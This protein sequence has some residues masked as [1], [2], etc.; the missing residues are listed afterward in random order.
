MVT[1][2]LYFDNRRP[3]KKGRG[4]LRFVI[5]KKSTTS[6][7]STGIKLTSDQW[8]G[9]KVV[10]HPNSKV[11]NSALKIN[12]GK[13][14]RLLIDLANEGR[15]AGKSASEIVAVLQEE[16]DPETAQRRKEAKDSRDRQVNSVFAY[17]QK[18][19]ALKAN[20]GTR[21]LYEDTYNKLK[22]YCEEN[23][24]D[25]LSLCFNDVNRT[26]L[27]SFEQFCLKTQKQNTASRHLRDI[28]AVFNSAIDDGVT[29]NYPFRKFK[30]KKEETRDKSYSA[31]ELR[32][33]F[34][35]KCYPGGEQE[36]VDIFKLM[37]CLIGINSV[38][39]AYAGKPVEG[40]LVIGKRLDY[41]RKKTGKPYSIFLG[42]E[43][44]EIIKKY[45]GKEHLLNLLER[46]P[47]YKTYFNRMAKTL[48]KVGL[49]RVSGKKSSGKAL[50][51]E[52]C[53]GSARTSWAT[54]AEEELGIPREVIAAALGHSTVDV[55]ST[56]LRTDWQQKVDDANRRV[57]NWV[58][59]N[60]KI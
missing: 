22:A 16:L 29:T 60:K 53:T 56:Y 10:N 55:T 23:Q 57:L 26:F 12:V 49:V 11:L 51:P 20:D 24:I 3:D 13:V 19:F 36:A 5:T 25:W 4:V 45:E 47:N 34:N 43:A 46:V 30:I 48:R 40:R 8:D 35:H 54:I 50:V 38:D 44:Q 27:T 17:F 33:L 1:S 7:F 58:F 2:K 39:L 9:S 41:T 52:I 42:K 6:M 32:A 28:R 21:R 31:A 14:E 37:F 59:N 18:Y 15:L